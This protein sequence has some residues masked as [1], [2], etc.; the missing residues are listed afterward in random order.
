M[1]PRLSRSCVSG[2][3]MSE[4]ERAQ[5]QRSKESEELT[6][7]RTKLAIYELLS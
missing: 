3:L 7:L 1:V 4:D 2:M 6:A 5:Y